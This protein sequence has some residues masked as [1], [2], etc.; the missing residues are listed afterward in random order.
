VQAGGGWVN[1]SEPEAEFQETVKQKQS[2]AQSRCAGGD[3][4]KTSFQGCP[5]RQLGREWLHRLHAIK[6]NWGIR[7]GDRAH[8]QSTVRRDDSQLAVE[9]ERRV[10]IEILLNDITA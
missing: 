7:V 6:S 9:P 3:V 5:V 1:D 2:H 4:W 10:E 8:R